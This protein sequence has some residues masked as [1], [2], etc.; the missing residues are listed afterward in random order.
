M[1]LSTEPVDKSVEDEVKIPLEPHKS[2]VGYRFVNN[3]PNAEQFLI[4]RRLRA[5]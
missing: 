4:F 2:W 3:C 5:F 1:T